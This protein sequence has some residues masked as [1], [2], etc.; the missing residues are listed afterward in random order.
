MAAKMLALALAL[1]SCAAGAAA[2]AAV[3]TTGLALQ[4][5]EVMNESTNGSMNGEEA[6][7]RKEQEELQLAFCVIDVLQATVSLG[8]AGV[9]ITEATKTCRPRLNP[10]TGEYVV[11][12]PAE[13]SLT[14]TYILT[15]LG[16]VAVFLSAAASQCAK[17][18]NLGAYCAMDVASIVTGLSLLGEARPSMALYCERGPGP[19]PAKPVNE[20]L[21]D[22]AKSD[23][24]KDRAEGDKEERRNIEIAMCVLDILQASKYLARAGAMVEEVMFTC[25]KTER[26]GDVYKMEHNLTDVEM[27]NLTANE[28]ANELPPMGG[29][30]R[31]IKPVMLYEEEGGENLAGRRLGM[32]GRSPVFNITY[33]DYQ[34]MQRVCAINVLHLITSFTYVASFLSYAA[35][36]CP[37]VKNYDAACAGGIID[38]ITG[39]T[40]VAAAG[41]DMENSCAKVGKNDSNISHAKENPARRLSESARDLLGLLV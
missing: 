6:K 7:V 18:V 38:T 24:E 39:L 8:Q 28:I 41:L 3:D 31:L 9:G 40:I 26:V 22:R 5:Q 30:P 10:N 17:S 21:A 27:D 32:L 35:A 23:V 33:K 34:H 19:E 13:C 14:I 29:S 12:R 1:L 37:E 25:Q 15:T 20:S 2:A 4:L 11:P 16:H 36:K